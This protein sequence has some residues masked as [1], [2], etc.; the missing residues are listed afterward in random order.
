MKRELHRDIY[1]GVFLLIVCAAFLIYGWVSIAAPDARSLPCFLLAV[2]CLL[3][4]SIIVKGIRATKEAEEGTSFQY[5]YTIKDVKEPLIAYG[6]CLAYLALFWWLGYFAATPVFLI[7]LMR[8]LKAGSWKKIILIT[9]I[10][11]AIIYITFVP[12]L[13]LPIHRVGI[14]GDLFR[15]A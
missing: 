11:T 7:A 6:M 14:L 3:S 10:Y 4:V 8:Y 9:L 12:V 1:I 13:G 2:M 15:F 5:S